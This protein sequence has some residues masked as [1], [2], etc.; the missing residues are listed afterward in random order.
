M[1]WHSI[2]KAAALY[3]RS[4]RTI[5]RYIRSGR[6][7]SKLANGL[8][9]VWVQEQVQTVTSAQQTIP[10]DRY[11]IPLFELYQGLSLLRQRFEAPLDM[12]EWLARCSPSASSSHSAK[13]YQQLKFFFEQLDACFRRVDT[14]LDSFELNQPIL[15]KVYRSLVILRSHAQELPLDRYVGTDER[16]GK[17]YTPTSAALDHLLEQVRALLL[18]CARQGASGESTKTAIYHQ[19]VMATGQQQW[20]G[21]GLGMKEIREPRQIALPPDDQK[22]Q[23]S[24]RNNY[25]TDNPH[26][27]IVKTILD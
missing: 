11:V 6:L 20:Q 7:T 17:P 25:K 3:Q 8:R 14:L 23:T 18:C 26:D 13:S 10:K 16:Q 9:L 12:A 4:P 15:L 22:S 5:R 21:E 24:T 27:E 19:Q 1:S 2:R